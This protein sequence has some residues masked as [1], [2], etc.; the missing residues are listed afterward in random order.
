MSV[1]QLL[2]HHELSMMIKTMKSQSQRK[3]WMQKSERRTKQQKSYDHLY[4]Q[5][6]SLMR[7][8]RDVKMKHASSTHGLRY[9]PESQGRELKHFKMSVLRFVRARMVDVHGENKE[10][11]L[12]TKNGE[13]KF[14]FAY[15]SSKC[16]TFPERQDVRY[17]KHS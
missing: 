9:K 16:K 11:M 6:L 12:I 1:L 7:I 8:E 3:R 13:R 5:L 10:G 15:H 17:G 2:I 14:Y 4:P